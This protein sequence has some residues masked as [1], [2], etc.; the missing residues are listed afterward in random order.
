MNL[1]KLIAAFGYYFHDAP[2]EAE[3]ELAYLN[4]LGH[5]DAIL[6]IDADV[7]AFGGTFDQDVPVYESATLAASPLNLDEAAIILVALLAG[8]D[9]D[10]GVISCSAKLAHCLAKQELASRIT[11]TFPNLHVFN[12]YAMPTTSWSPGVVAN[13]PDTSSWIPLQPNIARISALC[14]ELF[15]WSPDMRADKFQRLLWSGVAFRMI[16]S[17]SVLYDRPQQRFVS[18]MASGFLAKVGNRRISST[19]SPISMRSI[20][21]SVGDFCKQAAVPAVENSVLLQIP[22]SILA[23]GTRDIS[24]EQTSLSLSHQVLHDT[25]DLTSTLST[26]TDIGPGSTV[27]DVEEEDRYDAEVELVYAHRALQGGGIIDLTEEEIID[28]TNEDD[29]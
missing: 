26:T 4:K 9:Y 20:R 5:I 8:G 29:I 22:E 1:K 16:S 6:T 23:I 25:Q 3:A 7:F 12:L 11:K 27:I 2:G 28:L 14:S 17:S 10:E 19:S 18:F 13:P 24:A 21:V 15:D